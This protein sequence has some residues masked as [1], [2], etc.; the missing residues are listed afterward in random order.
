M[1]R[2]ALVAVL[3]AGFSFGSGTAYAQTVNCGPGGS[4]NQLETVLLTTDQN[5]ICYREGSA[6]MTGLGAITGLASGETLVGIDYR[7]LN[8]VLYGVGTLGG[9]YTLATNMNGATATQVSTIVDMTTGAPI[10]LA[11]FSF[12][13]DFNPVPDR[14]RI[15]S[16][17]GQNLRVNVVNGQTI[18][19]GPL[20]IPSF[21]N[22]TALGSMAV[23]YTNN[24]ANA[25][26]GTV[27]YALN[28]GIDQLLIQ[29]PPNAGTQNQVG[30]L[31]VDIDPATGFDI[32]TVV[33]NNVVTGARGLATLSNTNPMNGM[34]TTQI[35]SI[36]LTT[37]AATPVMNGNFMNL[38][39]AGL[40][41]PLV[42]GN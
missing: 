12:G 28:N 38:A 20:N 19:D 32:F 14:L 4:A 6:V 31:G 30:A 25:A 22:V 18:V 16:N 17:F 27:L 7:P 24:D 9:I 29:A 41:I 15:V 34:T 1:K 8:N 40:A 23:A 42:Q 11:G 5:L 35:Y 13:V 26:T 39:I 33:T 3:M 21:P 36:N 10:P 37:G 2:T